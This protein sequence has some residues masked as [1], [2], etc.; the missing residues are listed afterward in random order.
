MPSVV[1]RRELKRLRRATSLRLSAAFSS[2]PEQRHAMR[3]NY[4]GT[5]NDRWSIRVSGNWRVTL[6]FRDGQVYRLDYEDYH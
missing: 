5:D 2:K 4:R 1:E 3:A 6:G